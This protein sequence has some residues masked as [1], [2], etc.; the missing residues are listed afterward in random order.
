[1]RTLTEAGS[2]LVIHS[3]LWVA[4]TLMG[5][6][7]VLMVVP[8]FLR[9]PRPYRLGALLGTILFLVAGWHFFASTTTLEA[10]GFHTTGRSGDEE[11]VGWLQVTGIDTGAPAGQK[12]AEPKH[13]VIQ[14]RSGAEV[15]IDLAGLSAVEKNRVVSYIRARLAR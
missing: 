1:M 5:V 6:G 2:T 11:R 9:P 12:G 3:P 13:L 14:L 4:L 8:F 15:E 7:L 10:R